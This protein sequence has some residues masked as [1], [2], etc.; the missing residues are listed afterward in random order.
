MFL[1]VKSQTKQNAPGI[2]E[3]EYPVL[4]SGTKSNDRRQNDRM[5]L[6]HVGLGQALD[7]KS[8]V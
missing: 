7:R 8:V 1:A 6:R 4:S 3:F 5:R 2:H